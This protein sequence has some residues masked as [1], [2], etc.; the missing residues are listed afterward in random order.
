MPETTKIAWTE[1]TWNPFSGCIKVSPGCDHCYAESLAERHRGSA[2]FP[3]GFDLTLRHHKLR[4]PLKWKAP[5]RI[6]VNSMSDLFLG[7]V[8]KDYLRRVWDTMLEADWHQYQILTK[9]PNV[10]ARLIRYLGLE[11]PPHIWLGVS[12]ESQEW[13]D[14]R[15]PQLLEIPAK[16]KVR[17]LSCEPLLG[18]LDLRLRSVED[19]RGIIGRARRPRA[20]FIKWVITGGESGPGRRPADPAWFRSIRDQCIQADV[21]YFHKQGNAFQSGKDRLLGG[22]TWDEYPEDGRNTDGSRN[23]NRTAA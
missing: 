17:F 20:A 7:T 13:A 3:N 14:L 23:R 11:L 5:R 8:P 19:G 22:R 21:A 2:A 15:I 1:S 10:A 16:A 9:R 18:P 4:D 12:V 6:F